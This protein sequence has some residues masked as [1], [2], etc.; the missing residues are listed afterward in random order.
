MVFGRHGVSWYRF[1]L[2]WQF[3][4]AVDDDRYWAF[5]RL[6]VLTAAQADQ[7]D[8]HTDHK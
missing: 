5:G 2:R 7:A 8:C 1:G 4:M 6:N 3:F